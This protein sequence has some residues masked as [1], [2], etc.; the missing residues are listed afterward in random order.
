MTLLV[1]TVYINKYIRTHCVVCSTRFTL[2]HA[3]IYLKQMDR[4]YILSSSVYINFL[5]FIYAAIMASRKHAQQPF[6]SLPYPVDPV[7][8]KICAKYA[9]KIAT[10]FIPDMSHTINICRSLTATAILLEGMGLQ[11]PVD[12]KRGLTISRA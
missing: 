3:M 5:F 11:I 6:F 1:I 4:E 10:R 2:L 8:I 9:R 7:G 12:S